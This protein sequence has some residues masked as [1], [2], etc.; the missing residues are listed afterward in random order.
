M[1]APMIRALIF[2]L[3][4]I[5]QHLDNQGAADGEKAAGLPPLTIARYAY[6]HDSW[7]M[8][9]LGQ[10]TDQQWTDHV[11]R[12]LLADFGPQARTA[13]GPWR[14]DRGRAD[15][16]M[17]G[18]LQQA[19]RAMPC[20]VL[21]N[22]TSAMHSDLAFHS[23]EF[24]FAFSSADLGVTKPDPLA[25]EMAAARMK[26]NPAEIYYFG[27]SVRCVAGARAAGLSAERFT[28]AATCAQRLATLGVPVGSGAAA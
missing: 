14:A 27:D 4:G 11:E 3:Y 28:S 18:L 26:V 20:G 17:I 21:A 5:F 22:A 13:I 15:K 12:R 10:I 24:D 19:R 7:E 8:A 16:E 2:E 6:E 1:T 23:I 9:K 25:F